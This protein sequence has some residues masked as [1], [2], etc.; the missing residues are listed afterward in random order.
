MELHVG[1]SVCRITQEN[2]VCTSEKGH[3]DHTQCLASVAY[4][5][6]GAAAWQLKRTQDHSSDGYLLLRKEAHSAGLIDTR[7]RID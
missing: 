1:L 2:T 4:R 3:V 7:N 5:R 6:R